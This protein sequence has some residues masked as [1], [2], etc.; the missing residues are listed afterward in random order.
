M[1]WEYKIVQLVVSGIGGKKRAEKATEELNAL[2]TEGWEAVS[3]WIEPLF[4]GV[5]MKRAVTR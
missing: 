3:T 4:T 5:L 2:G 1:R